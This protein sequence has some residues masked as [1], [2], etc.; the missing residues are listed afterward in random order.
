MT[1]MDQILQVKAEVQAVDLALAKIV[2]AT[3]SLLRQIEN[4]R[5]P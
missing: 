3:T 4:P 5:F 1:A 2:K